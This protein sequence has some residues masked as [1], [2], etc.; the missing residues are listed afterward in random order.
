MKKLLIALAIAAVAAGAFARP[1]GGPGFGGHRPHGFGGPARRM[2]VPHHSYY[3]HHHH[4]HSGW[5]R[6]GGAFWGGVVGGVIGG[7]LV[8]AYVGPRYTSST[9]VVQQPVVTQTP[10]VVNST[11]V[12]VNPAPVVINA[13]ATTTTQ[14]WVEGRYVD[15]VQA[16]GTIVRIWQPGHY[17]TRMVSY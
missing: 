17:E 2:H 12:V 6:G 10:V 8:D 14:V 3:G 4:R 7:A 11:P 16:N 5:G 13:P 1:H 9:V 15:Q